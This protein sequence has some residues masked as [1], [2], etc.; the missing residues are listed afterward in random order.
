MCQRVAADAGTAVGSKSAAGARRRNQD[1]C[2]RD[3]ES[4]IELLVPT[5]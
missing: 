4:A 5:I 2:R 3:M 1:I